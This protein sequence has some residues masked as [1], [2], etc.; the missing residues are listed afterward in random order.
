MWRGTP[1]PW[2]A[3]GEGAFKLDLDFDQAPQPGHTFATQVSTD[4]G[5]T[6][7]TIGVGLKNP[8]IT[9]DR[10]QF[11]RGTQVQLRVISTNGFTSTTSDIE[12]FQ[13]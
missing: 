3:A 7:Q 13:V 2:R 4:A 1:V 6:W 10:S 11:P 9:V 12:S 5:R 8:A